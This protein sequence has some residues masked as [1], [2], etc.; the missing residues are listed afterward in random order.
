MSIQS[1]DLSMAAAPGKT[2]DRRSTV[3]LGPMAHRSAR[4]GPGTTFNQSASARWFVRA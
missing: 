3:D 4:T 2:V 1:D